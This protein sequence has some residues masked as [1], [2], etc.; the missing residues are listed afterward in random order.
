MADPSVLGAPYTARHRRPPPLCEDGEPVPARYAGVIQPAPAPRP[1]APPA[2]YGDLRRASLQDLLAVGGLVWAERAES[3]RGKGLLGIKDLVQ[4]LSQFDGHTWQDRWE[5]AGLN[6]DCVSLGQ[7]LFPGA[8]RR[9]N[10]TMA[11]QLMFCVRAIAPSL[12]G[13]RSIPF[14]RY[15]DAFEATQQDTE[16]S[17]FVDAVTAA[18]HLTAGDRLRARFDVAC[19]LTTQGIPFAEL[20][21]SALLH[22][23]WECRRLGL[24]NGSRGDTTRFAG[25]TAWRMLCQTGHFP[26]DTP[27]DLRVATYAGQRST[28]ELVD[29]YE[30]RDPLIRQLLIDYITRRRADSDY[31][32]AERMARALAGLFWKAIETINADQPSTL[33]LDQSTYAQWREGLNWLANGSRRKDPHGTLILVRALY[34]DIQSWATED[35]SQWGRWA[36]PCPIPYGELRG[37]GKRRRRLKERIDD[38]IRVRQPLLPALVRHVEHEYERYRDILAAATATTAGG[39]FVCGDMRFARLPNKAHVSERPTY[40]T[41][42]VR[43]CASGKILNVVEREDFTFWRWAAVEVLRL[44]GI[45]IE[46]LVELSHLSIRQYRRPNNEVIALLV[47]APSKTDR[48]R[49]IPMSAELFHVVAEIIRRHTA[50]TGSVPS[51]MRYDRNDSTWTEPMPFLF[52][53]RY[54]SNRTV[55]STETVRGWIRSACDELAANNPAFQDASFSPHDFRRLFATELANSGLPI[56]IGAALLGH[57]NLETFRGYVTIFD[58]D[59]IRH[60]QAHLAKRRTLRADDEYPQVTETEWREF[61]EHFDKRKVELGGCARPYGTPCAHEHACI[62]C[63]M[64]NVNPQMLARLDQIEAD[65]IARRERASSEQWLGEIEG[66][67]LT[68]IFLRQKRVETQRLT[69]LTRRLSRVVQLNTPTLRST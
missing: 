32:H 38:R 35:P 50:Q 2:P 21:P 31:G 3:T 12:A 17:H 25:G 22:Y 9:Q 43:E 26:R 29:R 59:V 45:R 67:D 66:I 60:Y 1:A 14:T 64:L 18:S 65:L 51:L 15:P 62:R 27:P 61:E 57:L 24:V 52:Q 23:A 7:V 30:L 37:Y 63:P 48:E 34:T 42:R 41:V 6:Q 19:A 4:H 68:L 47:I 56:H 49:V 55:A 5:A 8:Q 11:V 36:V 69:R 54:G 13:F 28:A 39:V 20:T 33:Q 58:E 53:R 46:E 40:E 10:I 16:L 44:S